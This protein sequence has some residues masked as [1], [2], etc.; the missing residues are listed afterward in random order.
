M[1]IVMRKRVSTNI[2]DE[3]AGIPI[4]KSRVGK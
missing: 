4:G 2:Y 3:C 1:N